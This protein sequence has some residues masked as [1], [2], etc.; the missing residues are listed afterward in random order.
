MSR[1]HVYLIDN[2]RARRAHLA[3]MLC[4]EQQQLWSFDSVPSFIQWIDY[5][6]IPESA[7]VLTH[8]TMAPMNGVELLDVFRAD[9]ISLPTVLIGSA[10][11]L[12]LAIKALRYGGTYVLWRPFSATL[13]NEVITTMLHEWR[14]PA[15]PAL[16]ESSDTSASIE[17]RF[18]SLSKRQREVL[19]QVFA[20]SGN[21]TIA[22]ALGISI[23][24]VELHR[25][26]MMKKMQA[27]SV[28]SLIR[29]LSNYSRALEQHT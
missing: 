14:A 28:V 24:T 2:D 16:D 21:Q 6:R 29:M 9:G 7:C 17:A 18:A 20:G 19:R 13:L 1:N 27:D 10:S 11:E 23:K 25:A 26:C 8:L 12:Q 3:Q 4:A 15:P 5:E 22:R